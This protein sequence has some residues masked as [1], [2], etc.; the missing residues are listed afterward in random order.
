MSRLCA[1]AKDDNS[2]M[3]HVA[4]IVG[5]G[6]AGKAHA[7]A[8]ASLGIEYAGPVSGMATAA[9][10]A[11]LRDPAFDVVHVATTNDLH[12]PL[13]REAL[14]VGKHVVCEKPL[15]GDLASAERLAALAEM[16]G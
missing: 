5:A 3:A 7:E 11:P 12:A 8:L 9:D 4:L 6:N 15:T 14:R 13:V 1:R 10:L 2:R 16:T